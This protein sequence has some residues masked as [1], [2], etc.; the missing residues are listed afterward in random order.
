MYARLC[1]SNY[2]DNPLPFGEHMMLTQHPVYLHLSDRID[3]LLAAK[4]GPDY[5]VVL[6]LCSKLIAI[7]TQF[8]NNQMR[9]FENDKLWP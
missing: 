6:D 3:F 5:K 8:F 1:C 7:R 2:S 9:K 4:K